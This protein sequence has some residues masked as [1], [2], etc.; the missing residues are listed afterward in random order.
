MNLLNRVQLCYS[1]K[2]ETDQVFD[3]TTAA[4]ISNLAQAN[5]V[6]DG[7]L[8]PLL[9]TATAHYMSGSTIKPCETWSEPGIIYSAVIGFPGSNKSRALSMFRQAC[10]RIEKAQGIE[11]DKSRLNQGIYIVITILFQ[12]LHDYSSLTSI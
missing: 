9:L 4:M 11:T 5:S 10:E 8:I 3:E 12:Q 6:P 7:Y 1:N 2:L